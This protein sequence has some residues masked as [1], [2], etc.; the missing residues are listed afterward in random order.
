MQEIYIFSKTQINRRNFL[1]S[2][3]MSWH[4]EWL[5]LCCKLLCKFVRVVQELYHNPNFKE[6]LWGCVS[7]MVKKYLF[8]LFSILLVAYIEQ[9][10]TSIRKNVKIISQ[11]L[12]I[13]VSRCQHY[14]NIKWTS[15]TIT[16]WL[17]NHRASLV[18][19]YVKIGGI[20][21]YHDKP[22]WMLKSK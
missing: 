8:W 9:K 11:I 16:C 5:A 4:I 18:K 3:I 7:Y 10:Q 21:M 15:Q 22:S 13:G 17:T 12:T 1:R 19:V 6:Y 14:V 20:G 2:I